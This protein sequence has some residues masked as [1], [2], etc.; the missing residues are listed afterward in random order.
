MPSLF[1]VSSTCY[2]LR[3]VW[4]DAGRNVCAHDTPGAVFVKRKRVKPETPGA[5]PEKRRSKK[6]YGRIPGFPNAIPLSANKTVALQMLAKRLNKAERAAQGLADP[7]EEHRFRP[8]LEH[9]ADYE[10]GLIA[11]GNGIKH[12]RDT[13][14]RVRRIFEG[15]KYVFFADLSMSGV[16]EFLATLLERSGPA[17]TLEPG[18]EWFK[19]SEA[20][21][22][23]GIK[24]HSIPPLV[25]RWR[26]TAEGKGKARRYPRATVEAIL[27]RLNRASGTETVNHHVRAIRAFARWLVRDRRLDVNLMA[28]LTLLNTGGDV[29]RGRRPLSSAELVLLL[30]GTLES[31]RA[32]RG[33]TGSDRHYLYLTA[34]GTGFR[35]SEL[36][37]LTLASF[38]LESD[39]PTITVGAG[40]TKNKKLAV[41]PVSADVANGLRRYLAGRQP[42]GTIW[43]GGWA[44]DAAEMLQMELEAVSIPY[45]VE[46][47][48]GP[49]YADFHALRHSYVALL[50]KSG[51]TLKE[52]MQLA[53]H[54]DPNFTAAIYGRAQLLDL[55]AAGDARPNL[56]SD[57]PKETSQVLRKTGTENVCT[58]FV[59]TPDSGRDRMIGVDNGDDTETLNRGLAATPRFCKELRPVFAGS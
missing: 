45:V 40:Y 51:A 21:K 52:A 42:E 11:K 4:I 47:P 14:A 30:Q 5:I 9:L 48:D 23:L 50:D 16:Q 18:K 43:S 49:L 33:L 34:C 6:W 38:D 35:A 12:A 44:D 10:R 2:V 15:C 39:S 36:A 37:M 55:A 22:A 54:S 24:G 46:G 56:R 25:K 19:K 32:F 53:R 58:G 27:Q 26:L 8:L 7:F 13:A 41:Q 3:N 31:A 1:R 29:R 17:P 20:A 57:G 59:Q 28:G